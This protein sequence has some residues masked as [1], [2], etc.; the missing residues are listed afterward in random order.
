MQVRAHNLGCW[1]RG[2]GHLSVRFRPPSFLLTRT[3][4]CLLGGCSWKMAA[5]TSIPSV[6]C[7]KLVQDRVPSGERERDI[8]VYEPHRLLTTVN[9]GTERWAHTKLRR[10]RD[11]SYP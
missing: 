7:H 2:T 10:L 1:Y 4:Y 5:D 8:G 11:G 9:R 3:D 6:A